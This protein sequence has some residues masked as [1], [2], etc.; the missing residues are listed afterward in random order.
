MTVVDSE[1]VGIVTEVF[2]HAAGVLALLFLGSRAHETR[3]PHG[4]ALECV[5][6]A[7]H[8]V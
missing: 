4:D 2:Q 8:A 7:L 6:L 5:D 1:E 3:D